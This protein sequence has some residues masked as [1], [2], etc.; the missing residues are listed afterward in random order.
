MNLSEFK[1][2]VSD[3]ELFLFLMM[4][5]FKPTKLVCSP[6]FDIDFVRKCV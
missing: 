5:K 1:T 2:N 3:L 6:I 4:S